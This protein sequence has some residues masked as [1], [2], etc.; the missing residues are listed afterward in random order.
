MKKI[1]VYTLTAFLVS[2][3]GSANA[4][5]DKTHIA[6]GEAIHFNLA[7]NLAS[8]DV[9]KIKAGRTE[10]YNHWVDNTA[11]EAI[12]PEQVK[13][14]IEKYNVA[15]GE[16]KGHLYGAIVAA[17]RTYQKEKAAGHFADYHLAYAGHYIGDLS[18]PLH[19]IIN[20]GGMKYHQ[21][22][23]DI[24]ESEVLSNL[25]RIKWYQ[26]PISIKTE[27]ELIQNIVR[28]AQNA[29]DL[30]IKMK[31]ENM[32][33]MTKEEAYGQLAQSASLLKAVL[34]YVGYGEKK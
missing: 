21:D 19:N 8:P 6:V 25:D 34:E 24:V 15:E 5:H 27:D 12:T 7:Y 26:Y 30:A 11:E 4:W 28:I 18:M 13:S 17:V 3:F 33:L 22:N 14:Q 23:D 9:A 32:R 1:V 29:K 2:C 20:D 31:K 10:E 16:E